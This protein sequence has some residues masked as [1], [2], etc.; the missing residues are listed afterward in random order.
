MD[1]RMTV[2]YLI[3]SR[4][5]YTDLRGDYIYL[6]MQVDVKFRQRI[7][8]NTVEI[9]CCLKKYKGTKLELFREYVHMV[10]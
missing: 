4:K 8:F 5:D 6:C 1:S 10:F 9:G 2:Y 7:F 3:A